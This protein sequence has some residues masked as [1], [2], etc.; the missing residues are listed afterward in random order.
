MFAH[1]G[2]RDQ[3]ELDALRRRETELA[4]ATSSAQSTQRYEADGDRRPSLRSGQQR[5]GGDEQRATSAMRRFSFIAA[6]RSSSVSVV[7]GEV[8]LLSSGCPWPGRL[9]C[10]P[11]ALAWRGSSSSRS[12]LK[13]G[14]RQIV[15]SRIDFTRSLRRPSTT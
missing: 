4:A 10:A 6:R 1:D 14:M 9:L 3:R 7:L 8:A 13:C 11:R 2:S 15:T 5:R 12:R